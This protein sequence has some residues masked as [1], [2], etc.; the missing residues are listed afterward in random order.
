MSGLCRKVRI[1]L[2]NLPCNSLE[3]KSF[4]SLFLLDR[5]TRKHDNRSLGAYVGSSIILRHAKEGKSL[6]SRFV[7]FRL[8]LSFS[9]FL[10]LLPFRSFSFFLSSL[11]FFS[12]FF[13]YFILLIRE[14]FKRSLKT[15]FVV[16]ADV[17]GL[18][19]F[20]RKYRIKA[21]SYVMVTESA[22]E[23]RCLTRYDPVSR[24]DKKNTRYRQVRRHN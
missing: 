16:S 17:R 12:L 7:D 21:Y 4:T 23:T 19:L 13:F 3:V 14:P 20:A 9:S 6:V 2:H 10:F 11:S 24:S 22:W 1:I 8:V 5:W 15:L 18:L